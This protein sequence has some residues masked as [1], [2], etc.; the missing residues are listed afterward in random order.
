MK[1]WFLILAFAIAVPL[2]AVVA[3]PSTASAATTKE[4]V[5]EAVGSG[6]DCD[7]N[8]GGDLTN[9]VRSIINVLSIIVGLLAVIM[10]IFAGAKYITSSGDSNK[11]TSAKN[12]L[13]YA[14]IGLII[15]ALAQFLVQ[16]VL[17]VT[18]DA[19]ASSGEPSI[20]RLVELG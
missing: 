12:A 8:G 1:K 16:K 9:V 7:A 10:I 4:T 20:I 19:T 11:V 13:I 17:T 6:A 18:K 15:V 5:C 14:I 3:V 2:A